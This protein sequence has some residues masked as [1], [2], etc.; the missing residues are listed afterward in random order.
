MFF[1]NDFIETEKLH[2]MIK[3]TIAHG[4]YSFEGD[5][6]KKDGSSFPV[7]I[8]LAVVKRLEAEVL[9][10]KQYEDKLKQQVEELERFKKATIQREIRMKELR[11]KLEKFE[12]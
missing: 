11:D 2:Q 7:Q 9:V 5:N 3:N 4:T 8:A 6:V 1:P 12:K 10:R